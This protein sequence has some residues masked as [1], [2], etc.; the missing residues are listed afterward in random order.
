MD[1]DDADHNAPRVAARPDS[2]RKL[3]ACKGCRLIKTYEQ[4]QAQFCENCVDSRPESSAPGMRD[5]WVQSQTTPD[6]E[7][8]VSMLQPGASWVSRWLKMRFTDEEGA[9]TPHLPG[10]YAI[11]LPGVVRV[12]GGGGGPPTVSLTHHAT[13]ASRARVRVCAKRCPAEA[14]APLVISESSRG[15]GRG[16]WARGTGSRA[17][18]RPAP[19][20]GGQSARASGTRDEVGARG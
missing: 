12:W 11:T 7:G 9:V 4:F 3:R 10:L 13:R 17:R 18:A 20:E 2:L 8:M 14:Y 19:R 5:D 15:E 1:Y 16:G 6:F